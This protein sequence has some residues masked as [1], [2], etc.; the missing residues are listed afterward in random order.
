MQTVKDKNKTHS[1]TRRAFVV[2]GLQAVGL[3]IL[4]TR[5][6]W[7]QMAQ[8]TKYKTLSDKNRINTKMLAP[9]RGLVVDRFGLK[10]A[11]NTQ[12]FRLLVIPERVTNIE[13]T[14]WRVQNLIDFP[15]DEMKAALKRAETSPKFVPVEIRDNL[16][17]DEVAKI[18]VHIPDLPGVFVDE[19]ALRS[20]PFRKRAGHITG[21][22]GLP[23]ESDL[24]DD[25]LLNLP[26]FRLGKSGIEKTHDKLLRGKAGNAQVEVNVVGRDIRTVSQANPLP[27]RTV[28]LS[29]DMTLQA[30]MQHRLSEHTSASAIV[31]DAYTGAVYGLASYPGYDPNL[32]THGLPQDTWDEML[33]DPGKPMNNKI[34]TGQYPPASTFKM[35]T[36]LAGLETGDITKKTTVYCPGYYKYGSDR[37]HCWK[38]S[39]HGWVD[40]EDALA[41]SC[42]VYFYHLALEFGI[43]KIAQVARRFGLGQTLGFDLPGEKSGLIPDRH[44]KRGTHGQ[45]WKPGETINASI[46]QGD[47]SATPLQLAVMTARLVNGGHAVKPW[48]TAY[49]GNRGLFKTHWP[50]MRINLQ[51]LA[52]LKRGMDKA[53]NDEDGTAFGSKIMKPGFEMG[54]KTGTA[55]VRRITQRQRS[56]GVRNEDLP[57]KQRHHALFVGYA[58]VHNPRY[59]CSVVVEHGVGGSQ[60]AAPIAR[61]ILMEAQRRKLAESRIIR[62]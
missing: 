13:D 54:G 55:Q 12:N 56:T 43:D 3:G 29:I 25:P 6:A 53:V 24:G 19:G 15:A 16:N 8:G 18:E 2:G 32:F 35:M 27:G 45:D 9:V 5:L 33:N 40:L 37:F 49:V 52:Y 20:Y 7:I 57:W 51:H 11:I 1:F 42:D 46:G 23:V 14:L 39:G 60:T 34:T 22:V 26:G 31:M 28:T 21:Y 48:I 10:M 58:P 47:V 50:K 62:T 44:W 17:W 30:Y 38:H 36:G 61:D 59:V 41:K 4:G